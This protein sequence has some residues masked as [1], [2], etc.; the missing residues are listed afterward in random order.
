MADWGING[1]PKPPRTP[2]STARCLSQK[3]SQKLGRVRLCRW[4]QKNKYAK[5]GEDP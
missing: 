4:P 2:N 1:L 5:E 3:H